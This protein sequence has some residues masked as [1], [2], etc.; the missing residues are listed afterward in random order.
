MNITVVIQTEFPKTHT[1]ENGD[2]KRR[3][4]LKNIGVANALNPT[5]RFQTGTQI[6]NLSCS[7]N[8]IM[9]FANRPKIEFPQV[10]RFNIYYKIFCEYITIEPVNELSISRNIFKILCL[11]NFHMGFKFI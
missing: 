4:L 9:L 5:H 6:I 10:G 1:F 2:S 11:F 3:K 7:G 8:H